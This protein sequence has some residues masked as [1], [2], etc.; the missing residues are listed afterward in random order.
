M[1]RLALDCHKQVDE[2]HAWKERIGAAALVVCIVWVAANFAF[3]EQRDFHASRGPVAGLHQM[4]ETQC[5]ACHTP[6]VPI[7]SHSWQA[8]FL[9]DVQASS[10]KCQTCHEGTTHHA[11]QHP[12]LSCAS[13]HREHRGRD[14]SLVRL[15]DRDCTQCHNDLAGHHAKKPAF[16][17]TVSRFS[18]QGHPEFRSIKNDPGKLKFNHELHLRAGMAPG[19]GGGALMTLGK[20]PEPLRKRYR[21]QQS[22]KHDDAPVQLQC[23]SCHQLDAGDLGLPGTRSAGAYMLPIAYE[24]H[25]QACHPLTIERKGPDGLLTIPHRLE[26]NLIHDL[27]FNH[28]TAQAVRGQPGLLDRKVDRVLPGKL[29]NAL[30]TT[31]REVIDKN[32]EHAEKD[33]YLS[34]RL[35]AE[36]HYFDGKP[37]PQAVQAGKRPELQTAPTK[38]PAV[39]LQHAKFNHTAHRAM[40][41]AACHEAASRSKTHTDVLI[42]GRDNC[43]QCHGPTTS[44]GTPGARFACTQCHQYHN[45]D[46]AAQGIGAARRN[47]R[48]GHAID[49]WIQAK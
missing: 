26:P 2:I 49:A 8:L 36:C 31:L 43:V 35:C 20:I 4:W 45:G 47:P 27:M 40:E 21:D 17:L 9:G 11:G 16:E 39:W 13:C 42:P 25:C 12:E 24:N 48:A 33:L 32:V 29:T 22:T 34:N 41:C 44:A 5:N 6:F 10:Q 15:T 30:D 3:S 1:P 19:T 18:A 28:F 37:V 7:R 38:V 14:A 46:H 23:A